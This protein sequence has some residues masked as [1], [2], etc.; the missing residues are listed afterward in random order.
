MCNIK[1][2]CCCMCDKNDSY[3]CIHVQ[4]KAIGVIA[5]HKR[6]SFVV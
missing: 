1:A 6:L 2:E 3:C 5:C 4:K